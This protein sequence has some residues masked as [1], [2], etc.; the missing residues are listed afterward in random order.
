MFSP[1]YDLN[2]D[3]WF[4][5]CGVEPVDPTKSVSENVNTNPINMPMLGLESACEVV[6][7]ALT[8]QVMNPASLQTADGVYAMARVNQQLSVGGSSVTYDN[9]GARVISFYSPRILTGGKLALRGV[10]CSAYPLDMSEY[11]NFSPINNIDDPF[12][13]TARQR[14]AALTPIVFVQENATPREI[15]FMVTIEWRV[16]FDPGNPATASHTHHDTLPDEVWNGVV[17]TMSGFGHGVE[18]LGED[19]AAYGALRT[20]AALAA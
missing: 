2:T 20:V 17:K 1:F 13:W 18:E 10:K 15:E 8:V 16:R 5:W 9:L 11:S 3:K 7:A 12:T 19:A 6:P 14:S 4:D